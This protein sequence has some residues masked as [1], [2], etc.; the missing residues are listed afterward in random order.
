[1]HCTLLF[2]KN[3]VDLIIVAVTHEKHADL[4]KALINCSLEWRGSER[5]AGYVRTTYR[6]HTFKH[7]ND[8]WML[9]VVMSKPKLYGRL[10]KPVE[11][12][13]HLYS[14]YCSFPPWALS[15]S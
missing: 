14:L 13:L 11:M 1:M 2:I 10:I 6:Q 8:M 5:Y 4:I 12:A 3:N 9:H 7:L 15:P